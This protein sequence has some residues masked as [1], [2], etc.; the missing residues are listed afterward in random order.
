M[1][2]L[3]A[4]NL[5]TSSRLISGFQY[6]LNQYTDPEIPAGEAG[7]QD[8]SKQGFEILFILKAISLQN[9]LSVSAL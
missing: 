3:P 6:L 4:L 5:S 9:N 1:L 2:N 8:D 7:I